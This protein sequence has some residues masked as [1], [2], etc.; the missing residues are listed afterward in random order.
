MSR[1]SAA[2]SSRSNSIPLA[3]QTISCFTSDLP[4]RSRCLHLET[5]R[6]LVYPLL[7]S[8]PVD[9]LEFHDAD[10]ITVPHINNDLDWV[11]A[12]IPTP[13]SVF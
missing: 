13:T 12:S 6:T 10:P 3:D 5:P 11:N 8:L 2:P 9:P 1:H 4:R 7:S